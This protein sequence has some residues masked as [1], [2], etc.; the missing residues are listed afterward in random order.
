M[1]FKRLQNLYEKNSDKI[2]PIKSGMFLEIHEKIGDKDESGRV[3]RFKGLVIKVKKP[4]NTDGSFTI[5]GTSA[6]LEI[7]KI[8]PISFNKF[9]KVILLDEYETRRAKLYYIRDKVGK[10]ARFKSKITSEKRDSSLLK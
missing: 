7:E 5:R 4:N 1:N 9:E 8:Y 3:W 6:G 2:L 10:G